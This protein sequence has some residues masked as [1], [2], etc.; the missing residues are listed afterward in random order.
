MARKY[1]LIYDLMYSSSI[2]TTAK[3]E[4][5]QFHYQFKQ[6]MS[7]Y[8][9]HV[10]LVPEEVLDEDDQ[11]ET[12]DEVMFTQKQKIYNRVKAVQDNYKSRSSRISK[13]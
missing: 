10:G 1:K 6:S 3:E 11:F 7:L 8:N 5:D 4:T 9:G 2:L 13:K 12:V